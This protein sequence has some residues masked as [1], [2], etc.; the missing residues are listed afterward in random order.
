MELEKNITLPA[1][2]A[3][4]W[5][6]LLDPEVMRQ[7]VPGMESV[8]VIG[9]TEYRAHIKVK[10]SFITAKFKIRT[11]IVDQDEPYYLKTEGSGDD[12]SVASSFRQTS[13]MFLDD[14]GDEQ[15]RMRITVRVELLGRLGAFG[16]N[17]MKTKADRMWDEFGENLL[18]LL[19]SSSTEEAGAAVAEEACSQA[20]GVG[21]E[22]DK[23]RKWWRGWGKGQP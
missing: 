13:E 17:V 18:R 22:A 15:T 16:L 10:I 12:A 8:E 4:V 6:L 7:C 2:P 3:D 14:L 19:Q 1:S 20:G 9:P 21:Q 5:A 11:L 23:Q